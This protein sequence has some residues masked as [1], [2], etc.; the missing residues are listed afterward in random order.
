[1]EDCQGM[2]ECMYH[3]EGIFNAD[4]GDMS[5]EDKLDIME[6]FVRVTP[7]PI[8]S[9]EMEFLC[10]CG[11]TYRNYGCV[12]SGVVSM[13][14]NPDMKFPDVERAHQL[15]VKQTKRRRIRLMLLLRETKRKRS[16]SH[17]QR[18][19][20]QSYGNP[21]FRHT[22]LLW[23]TAVPAWLQ[24][25]AAWDVLGIRRKCVHSISIH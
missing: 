5:V 16:L 20:S 21:C 14:W 18:T 6:S 9:C 15:K 22:L 8:K 13:L 25:V 4:Y 3:R 10:N 17:Q 7:M 12:H 2:Y 19:I 24:R 11:D 1:V 23:K